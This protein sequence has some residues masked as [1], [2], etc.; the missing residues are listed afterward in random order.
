MRN[1][2][3]MKD[4]FL[5]PP[6][7]PVKDEYGVFNS[8]SKVKKV[9]GRRLRYNQNNFKKIRDFFQPLTSSYNN[10]TMGQ[11]LGA[12][13]FVLRNLAIVPICVIFP[14]NEQKDLE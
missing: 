5:P 1:Y 4:H 6:A 14:I 13:F 7:F 3:K 9:E 2:K 12:F 10:K 8:P 11:R